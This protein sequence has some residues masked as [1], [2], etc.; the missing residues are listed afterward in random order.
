[1]KNAV[2]KSRVSCVDISINAFLIFRKSREILKIRRRA[3]TQHSSSW[4]FAYI[5]SIIDRYQGWFESRRKST[6]AVSV[7]TRRIKGHVSGDNRQGREIRVVIGGDW[8]ALLEDRTNP[9]RSPY[10]RYSIQPLSP[11]NVERR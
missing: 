7:V 3:I 6:T 10:D 4:K 1:M 9:V 5:P 2:K 8:H 11:S